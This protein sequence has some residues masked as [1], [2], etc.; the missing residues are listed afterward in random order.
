MTTDPSDLPRPAVTIGAPTVGAPNTDLRPADPPAGDQLDVDQLP[1]DRPVIDGP[2]GGPTS[3]AAH[4]GSAD[5]LADGKS[6]PDDGYGVATDV[7]DS[8]VPSVANPEEPG[9][10]VDNTERR[11][12]RQK[13]DP[14][15]FDDGTPRPIVVATPLA[16][17]FRGVTHPKWVERLFTHH[18]IY[19]P[20]VPLGVLWFVA[21]GAAVYFGADA[22]AFLY[23]FVGAIA[24]LQCCREWRRVYSQP[25]RIVA[26]VG[27]GLLPFA[28]TF[29]VGAVGIGVLAIIGASA[30]FALFRRRHRWSRPL[31]DTASCTIRCSVFTGI[32]GATVVLTYRASLAGVLILLGLVAAYEVGDF[33]I[34]ADS[35]GLLIGPLGGMLAVGAFAAPVAVFN[36]SPFEQP[37]DAAVFAGVIAVFCPLSQVAASLILPAARAWSP[38]L[39]RIDSL[40]V[41]APAW[42][43]LLWGYLPS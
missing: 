28:A 8:G 35:P 11:R 17:G 22:L 30:L 1:A 7:P 3:A 5:D 10:G 18:D 4:P 19:G 34:G 21:Q 38:A 25:S 23:G 20:R 31:L 29:G 41:T 33:V 36:I 9:D 15:Y 27:A 26:A 13:P 12:R 40:I 32:A 43:F 6:R 39:R 2:V 24:A 14:L 37:L 16:P 42:L